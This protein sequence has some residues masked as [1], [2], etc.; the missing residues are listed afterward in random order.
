MAAAVPDPALLTTPAVLGT[1]A[2]IYLMFL[3]VIRPLERLHLAFNAW[4]AA[5]FPAGAGGN[6]RRI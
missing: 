6:P 5:I 2:L 4:R 3:I 1:V